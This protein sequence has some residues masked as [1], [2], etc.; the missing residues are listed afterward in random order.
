MTRKTILGGAM[1]NCSP[2]SEGKPEKSLNCHKPSKNVF[3]DRIGCLSG[4]WSQLVMWPQSFP[5]GV[6]GRGCCLHYHS[7]V[8][9]KW[10]VSK[11]ILQMNYLCLLSVMHIIASIPCLPLKLMRTW[12]RPLYSEKGWASFWVCVPPMK[13]TAISAHSWRIRSPLLRKD[14]GQT[15]PRMV[16]FNVWKLQVPLKQAFKTFMWCGKQFKQGD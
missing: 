4:L 11:P 3:S 15:R 12:L 16:P 10:R 9:R 14:R 1:S 2:F 6:F 5:H 7:E 13:I 8:G